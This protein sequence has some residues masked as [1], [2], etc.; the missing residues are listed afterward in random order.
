[1]FVFACDMQ[2]YFLRVYWR[3]GPIT[4]AYRSYDTI[5]DLQ[6]CTNEIFDIIS[7]P[8]M[9]EDA[10]RLLATLVQKLATFKVC[11]IKSNDS[12]FLIHF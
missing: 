1:M 9:E 4:T 11:S 2:V 3:D 10:R 5:L 7:F 6:V 12:Y 8:N